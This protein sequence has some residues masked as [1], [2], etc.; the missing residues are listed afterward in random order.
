VDGREPVEVDGEALARVVA[1]FKS[2]GVDLVIDYEHQSLQGRRAPAAGWIKALEA[3][4][5]GLWARVEWTAQAQEYLQQREY[6]YFSP[7][8]RLDP[9]TRKPAALLQ[10]ALTNLP[11]IKDLPPLVARC[12]VD[13]QAAFKASAAEI[14]AQEARSRQYGLGI[15][16]GGHV[17]KPEKWRE[18]PDELWGDP[19]NYRYPCH[20]PENA[21]A[22]W[23]YWSQADN[24]SQYTPEERARITARIK[25]LAQAQKVV[26]YPE[27]KEKAGM[28]EELKTRMGLAPEAAEELL[29]DQLKEWWRDLAGRL[30]LPEDASTSQMLGAVEALKAGSAR[31]LALEEEL[32]G[33]KLRLAEEAASQKV[34]EALR[35]GKISPA[36]RSWAL[37]YCCQDPEGFQTYVA[38]APQLVPVGSELRVF[39]DEP[40][41]PALP[42]EDLEICKQLG[43]T[44][45][46]YQAAKA[47]I[48]QAH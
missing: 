10:V 25:R 5:D 45:A 22:A 13:D 12:Q 32:N 47:Q 4:E 20:T 40:G 35:L 48:D 33:L 8:L 38:K 19:V 43:I 7:V 3:R 11:A 29:F 30:D 28:R 31:G 44:P 1:A 27:E 15:K 2:R 37:N 34:E 21:R 46:Q 17:T 24:Q 41:E 6:R 39:P 18:V 16:E 42:P 26:I 23:S 36:Q 9:E 14:A